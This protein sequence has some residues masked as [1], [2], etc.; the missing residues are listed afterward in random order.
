MA[1]VKCQDVQR[2]KEP[3][4]EDRDVCCLKACLLME[5]VVRAGAFKEFSEE[6]VRQRSHCRGCIIG[7]GVIANGREGEVACIEQLTE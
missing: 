4:F 5:A 1:F 6:G 2:L 7:V 3:G